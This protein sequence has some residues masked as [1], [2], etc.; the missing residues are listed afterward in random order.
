M[1]ITEAGN[2]KKVAKLQAIVKAVVALSFQDKAIMKYLLNWIAKL[3]EEAFADDKFI[4]YRVNQS[5]L[6]AVEQDAAEWLAN[7]SNVTNN[8]A[9][10][11]S[12]TDEG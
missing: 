1:T 4:T 2:K 3:P 11:N 9:D 10:L 8:G 6:Q 5:L 7:S 12:K